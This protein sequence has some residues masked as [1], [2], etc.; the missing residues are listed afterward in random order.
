MPLHTGYINTR[1]TGSI[2]SHLGTV[3]YRREFIKELYSV[4]LKYIV[5]LVDHSEYKGMGTKLEVGIVLRGD[6]DQFEGEV[7]PILVKG[8]FL[9]Y[10]GNVKRHPD[11]VQSVFV[12]D[13]LLAKKHG[14]VWLEEECKNIEESF[15]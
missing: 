5:S 6:D 12:S 2:K 15:K 13:F 10:K 8:L 4:K 9:A 1:Q 11:Y 7:A 14:M 3:M